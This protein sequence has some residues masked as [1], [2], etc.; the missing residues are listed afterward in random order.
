MS[1]QSYYVKSYYVL[2]K[3]EP[4][5]DKQRPSRLLQLVVVVD[6]PVEQVLTVE[7]DAVSLVVPRVDGL[8]TEDVLL[9]N[10]GLGIEGAIALP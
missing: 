9:G 2:M 4:E 10:T 1:Y 8:R 5:L 6:R 3:I 7:G